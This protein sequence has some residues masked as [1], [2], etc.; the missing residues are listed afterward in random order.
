L[1]PSLGRAQGLRP[2][3]RHGN[4]I[5]S[6]EGCRRVFPRNQPR[7]IV[8]AWAVGRRLGAPLRGLAAYFFMRQGDLDDTVA[9]AAILVDDDHD[10]IQ[11]AVEGWTRK[12]GSPQAGPAATAGVPRRDAA[13]IPRTARR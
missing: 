2:S 10:L 7:D 1:A 4:W 9:I 5:A 8:Y 3:Q 6:L 13:S 11:K 12:P